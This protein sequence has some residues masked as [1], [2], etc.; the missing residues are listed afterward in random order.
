MPKPETSVTWEQTREAIN[1]LCKKIKL[2]ENAKDPVVDIYNTAIPKALKDVICEAAAARIKQND[3]DFVVCIAA[4][5]DLKKF[6]YLSDTPQ[7][8]PA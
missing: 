1:R 3:P 2:Y 4:H 8:Q 5:N 7:P 6:G